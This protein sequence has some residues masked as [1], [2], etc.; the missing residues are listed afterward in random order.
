M[1]VDIPAELLR[2]RPDV[3]AAERAAAAQAEQ[4]GIAEAEFYPHISLNGTLGYSSAKLPQLFTPGNFTSV[5]GPSFSWNIL[6]YGRIA[7]NVSLQ[8]ARFQQTLLDYRNAVLTANQEAEDGLAPFLHSQ[9][10]R[11]DSPR[12][13]SQPNKRIRSL[14]ANIKPAR[15]TIRGWP[16]CRATWWRWRTPRPKLAARSPWAWCRSIGPWAGAGKSAFPSRRL[17]RTARRR[18]L[19]FR[20]RVRAG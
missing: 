7:N 6:N 12:A 2:R 5:G 19:S 3:R 15:S 20:K 10:Q 11:S 14:S 18:P 9:E 8:D 1:A 17:R 4:I 16:R 13:W